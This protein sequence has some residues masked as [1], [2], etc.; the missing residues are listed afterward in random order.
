MPAAAVVE[1]LRMYSKMALASSMRV[2]HRFRF[3]RSVC[4][5]PQNDSMAAL[6]KR[7][8]TVPREGSMPARRARSVNAQEVN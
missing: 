7:P 5:R 1:A 4:M 8:P 3:G 6:S 2:D